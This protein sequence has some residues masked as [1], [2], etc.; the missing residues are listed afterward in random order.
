MKPV[1]FL[2]AV[3]WL[4]GCAAKADLPLLSSV[5]DFKLTDQSNRTVHRQEFANKVW[6]ADFIFTQCAGICPVMSQH[7]RKLQDKLPAEVRFVSFS[8]DPQNDTPAALS[9]YA[10]RFGADHSR[11]SFLTGDKDAIHKLSVEGFKLALQDS[12]SEAEPITHSS[13]FVLVDRNGHIRGYYGMEDEGTLE[14][15]MED[16]TRL[17]LE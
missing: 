5:P 11:W 4:A 10:N 15:L 17:S 13:R 16:A 8:V 14:R 7:M 6:V 12:G 1:T 3:L 2:L 9:A